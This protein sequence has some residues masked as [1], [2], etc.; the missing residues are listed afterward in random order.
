MLRRGC[1]LMVA[2]LLAGTCFPLHLANAQETG[3][4]TSSSGQTAEGTL[5][6]SE[7]AQ[8]TDIDEE[9]TTETSE[10]PV[11]STN[12]AALPSFSYKDTKESTVGRAL[13]LSIGLFPF[14]YFYSGIVVDVTRYVSHGFDSAYAPWSSS[15]SLTDSEM[16]TKIAV[17]S[18][19]SVVFGLLGAIL[20]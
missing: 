9:N 18:A 16:W 6:N 15:V 7:S 19:A 13:I 5:Q 12:Q 3:G 20:K 1:M 10:N 14:T 17:S 11:S 4:I 8:T 2:L